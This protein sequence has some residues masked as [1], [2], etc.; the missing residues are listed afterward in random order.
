[1]RIPFIAW[2]FQGIPECLGIAA[3]LLSLDAKPLNWRMIG[4]IGFSQALIVY[5]MRM[6]PFTPGVHIFILPISLA[7]LAAKISRI[8]LDKA[9]IYSVIISILIASWEMVMYAVLN[10]MRIM[11]F[12]EANAS[13][14][15]RVIFGLPQVILL[16][17]S[18]FYLQKR[19]TGRKLWG[20]S[21]FAV[22]DK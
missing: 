21:D 16:L 6:L 2:V 15:L 9:L 4:V 3:L 17:L 19:K 14:Y 11:T 5:V 18:A 1:M 13:L 20:D 12:Q 7:L 10:Y 22:Q 8:R